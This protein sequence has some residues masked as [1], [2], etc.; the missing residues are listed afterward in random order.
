LSAFE[1]ALAKEPRVQECYLLAGASDY[2]LRI[3]F[4]DM[5]DLER[6]HSEVIT[7]LPAV[8]RVQSILT[9]RTVKREFRLSMRD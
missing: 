1:A 3:V 7:R 9:I 4:R 8:D 2:L 6:L 5:E